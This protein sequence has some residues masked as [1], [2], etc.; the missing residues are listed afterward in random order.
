MVLRLSRQGVHTPGIQDSHGREGA[1]RPSRHHHAHLSPAQQ[2]RPQ[3]FLRE[4]QA[5]RV[6]DGR[7]GSGTLQHNQNVQFRQEVSSRLTADATISEDKMVQQE[8]EPLKQLVSVPLQA[9]GHKFQERFWATAPAGV[10]EG[11]AL[12]QADLQKH[13]RRRPEE[14]DHHGQPG[15]HAAEGPGEDPLTPST[16]HRFGCDELFSSTFLILSLLGDRC[17][18]PS[19][20]SRCAA[21]AGRPASPTRTTRDRRAMSSSRPRCPRADTPS[22]IR[23]T[24]KRV[25][26]RFGSFRR[27]AAAGCRCVAHP[28]LFALPVPLSASELSLTEVR[29]KV[30]PLRRLEAGLMPL[31]DTAGGLEWSSLVS[32][33]KAYEGEAWRPAERL[34][35]RRFRSSLNSRASAAAQR[36]VSLFTLTEPQAGGADARALASP[37]QFHTPQTPRTTPTFSGCVATADSAS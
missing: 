33:A 26:F 14:A 5:R 22:P 10:A 31:P 12:P 8:S 15:G 9:R 6:A 34:L 25:S 27:S 32:A 23:C 3:G 36:A 37:V 2:L 16:P 19:P 28:G 17:S 35:L 1:A 20:M 13:H 29:D 4:E 30:P 24:P 7:R 21:G 11:P 18:A